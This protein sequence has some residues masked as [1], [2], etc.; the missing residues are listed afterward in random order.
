[1]LRCREIV[2]DD[3]YASEQASIAAAKQTTAKIDHGPGGRAGGESKPIAYI[4]APHPFRFAPGQ[5]PR[6]VTAPTAPP[7]A[8]KKPQAKKPAGT[9]QP[10]GGKGTAASGK[11][12]D[13]ADIIRDAIKALLSGG[14]GSSG[15]GQEGGDDVEVVIEDIDMSDY[16]DTVV[17]APGTTG[18][19]VRGK[20]GGKKARQPAAKEVAQLFGRDPD[21]IVAVQGEDGSTSYFIVDNMDEVDDLDHFAALLDNAANGGDEKRLDAIRK[22]LLS[23]LTQSEPA[24]DEDSHH[25]GGASSTADDDVLDTHDE[26]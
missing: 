26:L 11:K 4:E 14:E 21:D 20:E 19:V 7:A 24:D 1:M 16:D 12:R 18:D 5:R 9:G 8:P 25:R 17:A 22:R 3:V 23:S 6:A 13:S 10:A 2:S 15:A